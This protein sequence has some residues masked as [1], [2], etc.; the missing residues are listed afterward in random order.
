[1]GR[2]KALIEID[3]EALLLRAARK[4][5]PRVNAL[6]ISAGDGERYAPFGLPVIVDREPNAGALWSLDTLLRTLIAPCEALPRGADRVLVSP[7]DT[8]DLPCDLLDRL[9]D[10]AKDPEIDAAICVDESSR[11]QPLI[12]C[13]RPSAATPIAAAVKRGERRMCAATQTLRVTEVPL[14]PKEHLVNLNTDE[15]LARYLATR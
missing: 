11:L 12:A 10:A 7:C 9:L 15:D 14:G 2:D 1:M 3:G 8:P 6:W 5:M 4:L 13:Y